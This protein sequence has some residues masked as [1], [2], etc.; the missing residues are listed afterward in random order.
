[1]QVFQPAFCLKT[2]PLHK[3]TDQIK[4][5]SQLL[6]TIFGLLPALFEVKFTYGL[7][8]LWLLDMSYDFMYEGKFSQ[9]ESN[10]SNFVSSRQSIIHLL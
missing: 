10:L 2:G 9:R 4:P 7:I 6:C 8:P 1:M 5:A 3:E